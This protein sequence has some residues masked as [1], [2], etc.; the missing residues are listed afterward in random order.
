MAGE[1]IE[2]PP[3]KFWLV[4]LPMRLGVLPDNEFG[5]RFWDATFGALAFLYVFL[6][7]ERMAGPLAG[8]VSGLVLFAFPPLLLQH[9]IR[10]NNMDAA[11][12][13]AYCGGMYH[14]IRWESAAAAPSRW[15]HATAVGGFF[16]LGFMTKFVAIAFLPLVMAAVVLMTPGGV[17]KVVDQWRVWAVVGLLVFAC[18][19]P[20]FAYQSYRMGARFW[21]IILGEHV[22]RRFGGI[23]A[24]EHLRPWDFYFVEIYRVLREGRTVWLAVAGALLILVRLVR[25]SWTEGAV[26]VL[27]ATLPLALISMGTS[28]LL[29]YTYAFIPPLALAAGY[30]FGWLQQSIRSLIVERPPLWLERT[31]GMLRSRAS[32]LTGWRVARQVFF[33][34]LAAAALMVT[35]AS[36]VGHARFDP[37]RWVSLS[38]PVVVLSAG[39][40]AVGFGALAGRFPA[41]FAVAL[42]MV[43]LIAAPSHPY[44]MVRQEIMVDAHPLRSARDCIL[45]VRAFER[46]AGRVPPNVVAWLPKGFY[47][48]PYYY[49]FRDAGF[50]R[51]DRVTDDE[52]AA[53]LDGAG[54]SQAVLLPKPFY[55]AFVERTGRVTTRVPL[56]DV[57]NVVLLL[58]GAAGG[59]CVQVACRR[60]SQGFEH[61]E[62][63]L[64][65][66]VRPATRCGCRVR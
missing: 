21:E 37:V 5:L 54:A 16:V 61:R 22:L 47:Q 27:W 55:D 65:R 2:K 39:V 29:H 7:G 1:F 12:V 46:E 30:V 66:R 48:H 36:L 13:L 42:P 6:I 50:E 52:L 53:T 40:I 20:W 15:R 59:V 9:G 26:V 60:N 63:V 56:V 23:L 41:A 44:F 24:V 18:V 25:Q 3:L 57:N 35:A 11:Q 4:A 14:F 33:G 58:P 19:S 31:V 51:H 49:Y 10:T 38:R 17:R 43:L 45:N 34:A 62:G 28:K 8:F 64:D 32:M